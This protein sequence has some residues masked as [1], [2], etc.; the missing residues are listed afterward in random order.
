M[1]EEGGVSH[2]KRGRGVLIESGSVC[3]WG[4]GGGVAHRE[5]RVGGVAHRE[6]EGWGGGVANSKWGRRGAFLIESG[7]GGWSRCS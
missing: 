6:R 7:G 4:G 1:G 2:R 5:R 3:V